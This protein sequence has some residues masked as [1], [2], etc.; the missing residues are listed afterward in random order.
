MDV[1]FE[2]RVLV[3]LGV[4]GPLAALDYARHRA[5]ATRW[6][7]YLF[8]LACA[9]AGGVFGAVFDQ[10]SVTLSPEYFE[11]GKGIERNADFRLNVTR[12]GFHAGFFAGAVASALLMYLSPRAPPRAQA[13]AAAWVPA[14]ALACA[15]LGLLVFGT[16]DGF[17][18][19]AG[20]HA[21]LYAGALVG[22][23]IAV[24]RAR[25][26]LATVD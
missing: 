3:L 16:D 5:R 11:V 15:P 13:R 10:L 6:R 8:L 21:G 25:R 20:L 4:L 23:A 24:M 7:E 18:Q 12:L 22:L 1:S 9:T 17:R 2:F 14:M 26:V 19:V